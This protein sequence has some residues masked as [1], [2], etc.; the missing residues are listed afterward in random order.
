MSAI[1]AR[2]VWLVLAVL[3]LTQPAR[4]KQSEVQRCLLLP[5]GADPA[6][7]EYCQG[8]RAA[9]GTGM[10]Q[11]RAAA[12]AHY[13]KAAEMGYAEAE[14]VVG[15]A[16]RQGWQV[17][18]N[19]ALAAHWYEKAVA[20]GSAPAEL[21]LGL[22]YAQG[23]GVPKDATKARQ[24]IQAAAQQGLPQAQQALA[25]LG[26]NG[27]KAEP[28]T[29]LW[30]QGIARYRAGDHAGAATLV[31]Q[32][33]QAGHPL[34][35]YEMV[36][37]YE[38]G[39]GVPRDPALSAQWYMRGAAAGEPSAEAAVGMLYEKGQQVRDDWIEAAKWYEKSARKGNRSG[40]FSLG[41]A[42]QF[43]IG[44]PL[45]LAEAASWYDKAAAQGDGKAA[46]FARYIRDNHGF[47][48]TS[49]SPE[50]QA[51]MA[52]YRMQPWTLRQPPAGRVFR[53]T[54]ERMAYFQ[55]WA[56]AAAAYEACM[57]RHFHATPGTIFRCPAPVPPG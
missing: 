29:D 43:G 6:L 31:L 30:N 5:P 18:V 8:I 7:V 9:S 10:E 44:V 37:L 27:L 36:Y 54:A 23:M 49:Y 46:Y 22:M 2:S 3:A 19:L 17:P 16:Y 4:A 57:S 21:D 32:A 40:E 35:M 26:D 47:D 12:F 38:N 34:A 48:G 50:E 1:P 52:P 13:L 53:N 33:A 51:I 20:Q 55:A 25:R 24:L 11:D 41:R 28:G 15:A 39:D 14:A 42:Y 56:N 45:N